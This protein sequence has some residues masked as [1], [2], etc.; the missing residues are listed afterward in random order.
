MSEFKATKTIFV[1]STIFEKEQYEKLLAETWTVTPYE[2]IAAEDFNIMDHLDKNTSIARVTGHKKVK[3][4]KSGGTATYLYTYFEIGMHEKEDILKKVSKLSEKKLKKKLGYILFENRI[5]V[6]RFLLYPSEDFIHTAVKED[7]EVIKKSMLT[8][9]VF[10]N[11]SL[12][13]LK[14]YLQKT[15]ALLE[16]EEVYWMYDADN[17]EEL[18]KLAQK[19]LFVPEY[20]NKKFDAWRALDKDKDVEE[21]KELFKKYEYDYAFI[22]QEDLDKKIAD[23]EEVYY[24]RYARM[25]SERYLNVVNSKTGEVIYRNYI[26]GLSYNLKPKH[27][28]EL[29]KMI[30]K[31]IKKQQ[32]AAAK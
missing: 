4:M 25:N 23:N 6:A 22:S 12:G 31:A 26:P 15:N 19:T 29:N 28:D 27:F 10:F 16:K 32:K 7:I 30:N 21:E 8:D 2:I 14:N 11:Y 3:Q 24:L 17:T 9:D 20:I 1:F 13:M 5:D 18:P